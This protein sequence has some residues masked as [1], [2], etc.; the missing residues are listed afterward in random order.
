MNK[1]DTLYNQILSEKEGKSISNF[2]EEFSK[3]DPQKQSKLKKTA[4]NYLKD[5]GHEDIGSSD[6]SNQ[7]MTWY[8][9]YGFDFNAVLEDL[10]ESILSEATQYNT[11]VGE[12]PVGKILLGKG[13][14]TLK[15]TSKN[16]LLGSNGKEYPES[17]FKKHQDCPCMVDPDFNN[18]DFDLFL[19]FRTGKISK[20]EFNSKVQNKKLER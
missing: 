17:Y 8:K 6:I 1:F 13:I 7:L 16:T 9:S 18:H 3:L 5:K 2:Q 12:F 20:E 11:T 15:K 19:D 10:T 14:G 4:S